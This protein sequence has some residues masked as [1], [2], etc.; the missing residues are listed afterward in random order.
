MFTLSPLTALCA[1]GTLCCKYY[2]PVKLSHCLFLGGCAKSYKLNHVSQMT[3]SQVH[4][5]CHLHEPTG[6]SQSSAD[7][8]KPQ[9]TS[10]SK[11]GLELQILCPCLLGNSAAFKFL[12]KVS[13]KLRT[14][15]KYIGQRLYIYIVIVHSAVNLSSPDF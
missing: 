14:L 7:I 10:A 1:S 13:F 3:F 8:M 4:T 15:L 9:R 12:I 2:V 11:A 5:Y 6:S